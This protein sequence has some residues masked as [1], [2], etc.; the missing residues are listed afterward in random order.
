ME[1]KHASVVKSR[2]GS[3]SLE[4]NQS[5]RACGALPQCAL[6]EVGSPHPSTLVLPRFLVGR[7]LTRLV[8]LSIRSECSLEIWRSGGLVIGRPGDPAVMEACTQ[9]DAWPAGQPASWASFRTSHQLPA[10]HVSSI[11]SLKPEARSPIHL[12]HGPP[13]RRPSAL[14][15]SFKASLCPPRRGGPHTH[16]ISL[17]HPHPHPHLPYPIPIPTRGPSGC[18]ENLMGRVV[19]PSLARPSKAPPPR[20]LR[21]QEAPCERA[22]SRGTSPSCR[23]SANSKPAFG[24]VSWG[25][26]LQ[27]PAWRRESTASSI[28]FYEGEPGLGQPA[29]PG[30]PRS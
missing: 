26:F 16:R 14:N 23:A 13:A 27:S 21:G 22:W 18:A 1:W 29:R 15:R 10:P 9:R 7:R 17:L 12:Q 6:E 4:G 11:R 20:R 5:M 28:R 2:S 19:F 3:I 24:R 8:Q 25:P 30:S